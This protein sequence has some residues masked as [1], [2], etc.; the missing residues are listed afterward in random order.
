MKN[1]FFR[2]TFVFQKCFSI[3]QKFNYSYEHISFNASIASKRK[4]Y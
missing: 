2:S 3:N 1:C 4:Q